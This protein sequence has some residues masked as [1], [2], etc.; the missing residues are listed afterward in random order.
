M[1]FWNKNGIT[2]A[3]WHIYGELLK[4]NELLKKE[5]ERRA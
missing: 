5:A 2:A 4:L 3:L 1:H